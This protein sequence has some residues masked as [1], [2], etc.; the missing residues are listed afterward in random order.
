MMVTFELVSIGND[1]RG[2]AY[3]KSEEDLRNN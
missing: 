3:I 2:E 1:K